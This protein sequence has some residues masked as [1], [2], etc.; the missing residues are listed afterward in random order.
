[1]IGSNNE[2]SKGHSA[3]TVGICNTDG[4]CNCIRLGDTCTFQS[5]LTTK[6]FSEIIN[7]PYNQE[8]KENKKFAMQAFRS[9][10]E[11][12]AKVDGKILSEMENL[13]SIFNAQDKIPIDISQ[14]LKLA[15]ANITSFIM[16]NNNYTHDDAKLIKL[17]NLIDKWFDSFNACMSL[18]LPL[19]LPKWTCRFYFHKTHK[20]FEQKTQ[21]LRE[22]LYEE[23][24]RHE[25]TFDSDNLRD[26]TDV[27][28]K[29]RDIDQMGK[30]TFVDTLMIFIPDSIDTMALFMNWI[31]L[32]VTYHPDVQQ[33]MQNEI[34]QVIGKGRMVNIMRYSHVLK[35]TMPY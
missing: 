25:E 12:R 10:G 31:V 34:D 8:L 22:Y 17:V 32:H 19:H 33:K 26:V 30:R 9:F 13:Q 28:L 16:F 6:S 14:A 35:I 5:N 1:M 24:K 21:H 4:S 18:Q 2:V 3:F 23:I 29:N 27:Y 20:D 11:N 7:S 15:T